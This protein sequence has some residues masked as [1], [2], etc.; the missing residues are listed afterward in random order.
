MLIRRNAM[1]TDADPI[2]GNWYMH[3]DRGEKFE[4][5]AVDEDAR[6]IEIQYYDG[7]IDEI[8]L[9]A[10][11]Q[12]P[13]DPIEPPEDQ[14]A[15]LDRVEPDDLDYTWTALPENWEL[16]SEDVKNPKKRWDD[17]AG[18]ETAD[19]ETDAW[20]ESDGEHWEK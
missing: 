17:M 19:E 4:V 16:A 10:W 1:A 15:P 3:L 2:V 13:L 6:L 7:D 9:Y 11:Y 20:D 12:L 18:E 14:T 8:D 5:V